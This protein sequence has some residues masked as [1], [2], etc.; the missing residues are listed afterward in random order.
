MRISEPPFY[1]E[2]GEWGLC[3]VTCGPGEKTRMRTCQQ[4]ICWDGTNC[5]GPADDTTDCNDACCPGT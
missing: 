3:S 2:W 1:D 5:T 4:P